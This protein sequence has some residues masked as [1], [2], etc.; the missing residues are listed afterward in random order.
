MEGKPPTKADL[1]R[2]SVGYVEAASWATL[3]L[4]M[5]ALRC[6]TTSGSESTARSSWFTSCGVSRRIRSSAS[7]ARARSI[8]APRTKDV[9]SC[10]CTLAAARTVSSASGLSRRLI[11]AD[12]ASGMASASFSWRRLDLYV[13][14]TYKS[15]TRRGEL[16]RRRCI[17]SAASWHRLRAG[18][19]YLLS[20]SSKGLGFFW[21]LCFRG[22]SIP[23]PGQAPSMTTSA[24]WSGWSPSF[25]P[26]PGTSYARSPSGNSAGS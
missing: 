15:T 9:R 21:V 19:W 7:T 14:E 10:C 20:R 4:R 1:S 17:T 16:V 11:R 5:N 8:A 13:Y 26:T 6:G 12:L 25:S 2:T 22:C 23:P 18:A 3:K 24:R